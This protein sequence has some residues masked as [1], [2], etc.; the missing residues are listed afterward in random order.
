M[1]I[2]LTEVTANGVD[3]VGR[4]WGPIEDKKGMLMW[5]HKRDLHVDAVYQRD[6][7]DD[8]VSKITKSFSW[9][10][11]GVIKVS[12]RDGKYWVI[13]GQHRVLAAKRRSDIDELPC[14]V[15]IC[16]SEEQEANGFLASNVEVKPMP[17]IAKHKAGIVAK[18]PECIVVQEM[19]DKLGLRPLKSG[20]GVG[21]VRCMAWCHKKAKENPDLFRLVIQLVGE[22][23]IKDNL[24]VFES[25]LAGIWMMHRRLKN[26]LNDPRLVA[27]LRQIGAE[28]LLDACDRAEFRRERRGAD[29]WCEAILD[30]AEKGLRN[31]FER[32]GEA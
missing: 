25:L 23:T 6:A 5:I 24:P 16:A 2:E 8:K 7:G 31:K 20:S 28:R 15:F 9:V 27:R 26:G 17:A 30:E 22:M 1:A 11:C 21:G 10:S 4:Y 12:I 14:I 13:D 3:K 18:K 19:F 32:K 29:V